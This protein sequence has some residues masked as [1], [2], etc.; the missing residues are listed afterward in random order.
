MGRGG[1][2]AY[3]SQSHIPP[4]LPPLALALPLVLPLVLPPPHLSPLQERIVRMPDQRMMR[5]KP[6]HERAIPPERPGSMIGPHGESEPML[7]QAGARDAPERRP[8]GRRRIA[9]APGVVAAGARVEGATVLV[10]ALGVWDT[11]HAAGG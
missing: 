5:D 8:D 10:G 7:G 9:P 3:K 1:N 6:G 4:P 2:S 11:W